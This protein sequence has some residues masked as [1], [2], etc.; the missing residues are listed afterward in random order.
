MAETFEPTVPQ[1]GVPP[2]AGINCK[3]FKSVDYQGCCGPAISDAHSAINRAEESEPAIVNNLNL[4]I[5]VRERHRVFRIAQRSA[6]AWIRGACV[7]AC[8]RGVRQG[9]V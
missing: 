1:R 4:E 2:S 6:K 5:A 7:R 8:V 9:G 3:I